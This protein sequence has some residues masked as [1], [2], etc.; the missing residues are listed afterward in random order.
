MWM[1]RELQYAIIIICTVW[2]GVM[3]VEMRSG[4]FEMFQE[5]SLIQYMVTRLEMGEGE[6]G[7]KDDS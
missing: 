3:P 2:I 1:W 6:E 4:R 7:T 5:I